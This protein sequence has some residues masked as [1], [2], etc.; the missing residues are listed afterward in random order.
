VR[1]VHIVAALECDDTPGALTAALTHH[2]PSVVLLAAPVGSLGFDALRLCALRG[3][4]VLVLLDEANGP[5]LGRTPIASLGGLP[6]APLRP[7]PV[8]PRHLRAKRALDVGLTIVA[9][10]LLVPV[11]AA[12]AIAVRASGRGPILFR[13]TRVGE[14]GRTFTVLKFRTMVVDA[15]RVSGPVLALQHDPRATAVGGV[16]RRLHLDELPQL[17]NVLRGE[18]S[19]VGPRPERPELIERLDCGSEYE[20]RHVL[21]PGVTGL[22]QL[23]GTYSSSVGDKLRCDLLYIGSRSVAFDLRL[24]A[25]TGVSL[26]RGFS[27]G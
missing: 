21:R 19:L 7:L 22:A 9:L 27:R 6:W 2:S 20:L 18:M 4:R 24:I 16:L 17:W 8:A 5:L 3:I 23:V 14:G 25:A 1:E 11:L 15:E 26:L 10:P 12:I 13:Q